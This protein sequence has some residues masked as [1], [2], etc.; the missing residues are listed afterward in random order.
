MRML[1]AHDLLRVLFVVLY[2]S[3]AYMPLMLR[4]NWRPGGDV[5]HMNGINYDVCEMVE[6]T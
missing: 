6:T 4:R 2:H 1:F 5:V 3:S